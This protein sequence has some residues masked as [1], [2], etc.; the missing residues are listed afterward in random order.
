MD[1]IYPEAHFCALNQ[2]A[3][4]KMILVIAWIFVDG[5]SYAQTT[6]QNMKA[7][8][9]NFTNPDNVFRIIAI[10]LV[11]AFIMIPIYSMS[12]AVKVLAKK[13]EKS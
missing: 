5:S 8:V 9:S 12:H 13:V 10:L 2:I 11:V 3:M 7:S 1:L 4:K 6:V